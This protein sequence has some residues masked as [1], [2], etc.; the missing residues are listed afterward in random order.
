MLGGKRSDG[1]GS[2]KRWIGGYYDISGGLKNLLDA[3][4]GILQAEISD[5]GFGIL[6]LEMLG[7]IQQLINFA[8]TYRANTQLNFFM[9]L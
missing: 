3:K 9:N 4:G 2:W 8:Q 5:F 7:I 6:D 1:N